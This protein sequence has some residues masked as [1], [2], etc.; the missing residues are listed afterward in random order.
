MTKVLEKEQ[1]GAL[2][3]AATAHSDVLRLIFRYLSPVP[4][5]RCFPE[6]LLAH[7]QSI[8]RVAAVNRQWRATAF[9]TFYRTVYVAIGDLQME[10]GSVDSD[11]SDS[12]SA[13]S[14]DDDDSA[15]DSDSDDDD[16]IDD[17]D[18]DD[19]QMEIAPSITGVDT[20]L[21]ETDNVR[22]VQIIVQGMGQ[23]ADQLMH[24]LQLAGLGGG[25]TVWP[26]IER[27]RIDMCY[28]DNTTQSEVRQD[29]GPELPDHT[30]F[31]TGHLYHKALNKFL[32]HGNTPLRTL[33]I[34][35]DCGPDVSNESGKK[36][37]LDAPVRIERLEIDYLEVSF[38]ISIPP[39]VASSLVEL[40][41]EPV[42]VD[43]VWKPFV[44]EVVPTSTRAH[45]LFSS[46][47]T[48]KFGFASNS[49]FF[50]DRSTASR[51][52]DLS[53]SDGNG[54]F[55]KIEPRFMR[56]AKYG[57]PKFPV[58]TSLEIRHFPRSLE[59]FLTLFAASPIT[60][61]VIC[62]MTFTSDVGLDLSKFRGLCSLG[63]RITDP[64][65]LDDVAQINRAL[66]ATFSTV[67]PNLQYLTLAMSTNTDIDESLSLQLEVPPF[68]HSLR[69]LTLEG[70]YGQRDSEHLLQLFPYLHRLNICAIAG[71]PIT[72]EPNFVDEYRRANNSQSLTCL[73]STLRV[74]NAYSLRF[75]TGT[76][77][78]DCVPLSGDML[79]TELDNYRGLPVGL[80]CR[81][82]A[83]HTMR[84]C[85]EYLDDANDSIHVLL[86]TNVGPGHIDCLRRL[87]VQPLDK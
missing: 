7:M 82:P 70:G 27:L 34:A 38:S 26:G 20:K 86:E 14:F 42:I 9:P 60:S 29:F 11:D 69:S 31:G 74:L 76:G 10:M 87:K 48:L 83:L 81:L 23:T 52:F 65:N 1:T 45:L 2:S 84:A 66:S 15:S 24:Q 33:R 35:A 55:A 18:T 68:A 5:P 72:T 73:N 39:I 51:T 49:E 78:S 57:P 25:K 71:E 61:L 41:L 30:E 44:S 21:R 50:F 13:Y 17:D 67:N 80:V 59:T 43:E 64:L 53:S 46:L 4:P 77:G 63:I 54:L 47:K 6:A 8:Q 56:S 28:S 58:L 62:D 12:H 79:D 37:E 3:G 36:K 22:E 19:D 32:L 40:K 85:A 75:F 16:G